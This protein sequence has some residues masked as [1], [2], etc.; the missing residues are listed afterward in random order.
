MSAHMCIHISYTC[1]C[2]CLYRCRYTCLYTCLYACLY[3]PL[4]ADDLPRPVESAAGLQTNVP[5]RC[6]VGE[7][8]MAFMFM[9]W[10]LFSGFDRGQ[11]I[12][13]RFFAVARLRVIQHP[14][15]HCNQ[16]LLSIHCWL[17]TRAMLPGG[18]QPWLKPARITLHSSLQLHMTGRY[19]HTRPHRTMRRTVDDLTL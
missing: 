5:S 15:V 18:Y 19:M 1:I 2:T 11:V 3:R 9:L 7:H 8:V 12:D 4:M 16:A 14:V 6:I 10:G 17:C 13:S